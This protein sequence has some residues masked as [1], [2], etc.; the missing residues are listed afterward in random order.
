MD[1]NHTETKSEPFHVDATWG[2]DISLQNSTSPKG[3]RFFQ[4]QY[5]L[6]WNIWIHFQM[7]YSRV[8]E[9]AR[10]D[11]LPKYWDAFVSESPL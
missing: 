7:T 5:K 8:N 3:F 4:I 6:S 1:L 11:Y 2:S 10:C 9:I